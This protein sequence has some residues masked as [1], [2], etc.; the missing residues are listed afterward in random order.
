MDNAADE[1]IGITFSRTSSDSDLA[2]IGMTEVNELTL[3]S[4]EGMTFFTGGGSLYSSTSEVMRI[5]SDGHVIAPYGV[6]LGT[7][8]GTYNA[9]N[10]L[11]DYEEGT[12]TATSGGS[13]IGGGNYRKIGNFVYADLV[14]DTNSL[15]I[16]SFSGLPFSIS[17]ANGYSGGFWGRLRFGDVLDA[18]GVPCR[19]T[20]SGG[21]V[22]FYDNNVSGTDAAFTVT[23][24]ASGTVRIGLTLIGF[25][26]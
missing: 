13:S 23:T 10:T 22:L 7:A 1:G 14:I 16:T 18:N 3:A 12:W 15:S 9:A 25:T 26:T 4:R 21:S 11:D 6:T 24:E 17:G 20:M 5:D 2:A 19:I 8:V